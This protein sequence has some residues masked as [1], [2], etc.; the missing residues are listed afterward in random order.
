MGFVSKIALLGGLASSAV[1]HGVVST[2]KA[3][4][5]EY[6]GWQNQ[7]LKAELAGEPIPEMAAWHARNDDMGFVSKEDYKTADI[8]CH[9]KATAPNTTA[10]VAAGGEVEF[11]WN[12]WA[13]NHVGLVFTYVANCGGDCEH[14]DIETLKWVKIDGVGKNE[15]TGEWSTEDLIANDAAW[16]TKVPKE[17]VA[18]SYVFRH[19]IISIPGTQHYPQCIS[20]DITGDGTEDPEGVIGTEL[21]DPEGI[22]DNGKPE[23][24]SPPG[25]ALWV[26]GSDDSG[27]KIPSPSGSAAPSGTGVATAPAT[28]AESAAPVETAAS[29]DV[30]ATA[31]APAISV[32]TSAETAAPTET[33]VSSDVASATSAAPSATST[34]ESCKLKRRHAR[35]IRA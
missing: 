27:S 6:E 1:A 9:K 3:D 26:P 20:I 28:S 23:D 12:Q 18:G 14:V 11:Q 21:Y 7:Y 5:V 31:T 17:L 16:V 2:F 4:G 24:Y 32:E 8:I 22:I 33:V 34:K 25:P 10:T 35:H 15:E 29:S 30:T 19:E 13:A